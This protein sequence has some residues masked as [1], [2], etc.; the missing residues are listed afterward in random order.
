MAC[1]IRWRWR[2]GWRTCSRTASHPDQWDGTY[3]P[4]REAEFSTWLARQLKARINQRIVLTR[5]AEI[6]P[7]L[8]ADPAEEIDLLCTVITEETQITVPI[9]VK[10]NWNS[11]V[12][13]ALTNQLADRYLAG[14][15]GNE[16]IYIVGC[17]SGAA[18]DKTDKRRHT[19]RRCDP[20]QLTDELR[21]AANTLK[22]QGCT[23]HVRVLGIPL[24]SN[25]MR[26]DQD[27]VTA[28]SYPGHG[29][30]NSIGSD[31]HG[32][33]AVTSASLNPGK[34]VV[35]AGRR[36]RDCRQKYLIT[37]PSPA[38]TC[39]HRL[40]FLSRRNGTRF[41]SRLPSSTC[42]MMLEMN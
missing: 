22:G 32:H 20:K 4:H 5:E 11:G 3:V 24:D 42:Q 21:T 28:Q 26:E 9:E 2:S 40:R 19:V 1:L 27:Q 41:G 23:V 15:T 13:T 8:G 18:W 6:Q 38:V 10:C 39:S 7:R 12:V 17:F 31:G 35:L 14:P 30:T 25:P 36:G 34:I 29:R 16:G 33:R 37:R